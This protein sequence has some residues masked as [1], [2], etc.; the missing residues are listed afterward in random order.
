[1]DLQIP[2]MEQEK[3]Q[4]CEGSGERVFEFE[5]TSRFCCVIWGKLLSLS[6]LHSHGETTG[7]S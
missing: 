3:T 1:M 4:E 5:F 7:I 2:E 6:R